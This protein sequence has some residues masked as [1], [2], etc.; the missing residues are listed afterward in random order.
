MNFKI[1]EILKELRTAAV[2]S[3]VLAA[4]WLA[5]APTYK[6]ALDRREMAGQ[7]VAWLLIKDALSAVPFKS[8]CTSAEGPKT[9]CEGPLRLKVATWWDT[10]IPQLEL[11]P[12]STVSGTAAAYGFRIVFGQSNLLPFSSYSVGWQDGLGAKPL[13][14]VAP[15][16]RDAVSRALQDAGSP[17]AWPIDWS[18][19]KVFLQSLGWKGASPSLDDAEV[20]KVINDHLTVLGSILGSRESVAGMPLPVLMLPYVVAVL[21]G[22]VCCVL[23]GT[24]IALRIADVPSSHEEAGWV[25]TQVATSRWLTG[26]RNFASSMLGAFVLAVPASA[27]LQAIQGFWFKGILLGNIV[28]L[29]LLVTSL[30]ALLAALIANLWAQRRLRIAIQNAGKTTSTQAPLASEDSKLTPPPSAA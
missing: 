25:M 5:L 23:A 6:Y 10:D 20:S 15:S 13:H 2:F 11:R 27:L 18:R 30:V 29:F 1:S 7:M 26:L 21:I 17:A 12:V 8:A 19:T 14:G 9:T 24:F 16:D 4:A 3:M 28:G 22:A